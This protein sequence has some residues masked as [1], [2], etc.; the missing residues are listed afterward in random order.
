MKIIYDI[1][2][3]ST[4]SDG[5]GGFYKDVLSF[6]TTSFVANKIPIEYDITE[7]DVKRIDLL[8]QRAY[9]APQYDDLVLLLNNIGLIDEAETGTKIYLPDKS[10]LDNFYVKMSD[11][12]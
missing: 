9:G 10:D 4:T 5:E 12:V 7:N 2:S 8:M 6:R 3:D 11:R 1:M